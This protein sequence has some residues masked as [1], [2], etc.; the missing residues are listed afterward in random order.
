MIA[1]ARTVA[2][3]RAAVKQATW[4]AKAIIVAKARVVARWLEA[5]EDGLVRFPSIAVWGERGGKRFALLFLPPDQE[6]LCLLTP[7]MG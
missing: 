4:A 3:A 2:K 7:S 5:P 1:K 6:N